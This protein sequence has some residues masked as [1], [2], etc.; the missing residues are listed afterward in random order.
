MQGGFLSLKDLAQHTDTWIEP[1]STN[2]RGYDVY[3]LPP[4][5]QGTAVLQMLNILED[6]DI[7][8]M[9]YGST[10]YIHHLIEAKKLAFEDRAKFY[11]DPEYADIPV[12]KLISKAYAAERRKLINSQKTSLSYPPGEFER[13]NT[14]YLTV[15]DEDGNMVSLIQSNFLEM[16]SGMVPSG[17]GFVMKDGKP[18]ISFGVMGGAMQPQ[19]HVQVLVNI[20]DFGMN[21]QAAGY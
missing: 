4:N 2:Y 16:G 6:Y 11:A 21:L 14:I 10:E 8:S 3:E 5:G 20:I 17:L 1:I 7:A 19:G 9:G 18:F 15:A 13:S 12:G